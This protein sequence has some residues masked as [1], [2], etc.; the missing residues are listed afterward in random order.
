MATQ[1]SSGNGNVNYTNNTG[2]NVRVI[3]YYFETT[4][5]DSAV[6]IGGM[7]NLTIPSYTTLGKYLAYHN[8]QGQYGGNQTNTGGYNTRFGM[9]TEFVLANT[10]SFTSTNTKCYN[11]LIIPEGG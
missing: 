6:S 5:S 2:Q 4:T 10:E 7:Q 8:N 9:P 11:L 3:V 1:V